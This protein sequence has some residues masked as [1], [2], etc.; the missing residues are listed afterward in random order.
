MTNLNTI[1]NIM[2]L[3]PENTLRDTDNKSYN[4]KWVDQ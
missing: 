2:Q 1:T 3:S 4:E